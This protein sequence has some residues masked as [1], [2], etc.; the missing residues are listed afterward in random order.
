MVVLRGWHRRLA[1]NRR[2]ACEQ[3]AHVKPNARTAS[4]PSN[5][6]RSI[7]RASAVVVILPPPA[8]RWSIHLALYPARAARRHRAGRIRRSTQ[9]EPAPGTYRRNRSASV[10]ESRRTE[11]DILEVAF[12]IEP[13]REQAHHMHAR[14]AAVGRKFVHQGA[15]T[16]LVWNMFGQFGNDM[17]QTMRLSLA[18][19]VVGDA[20]RILNV[21]LPVQHLP[22]RAGLRSGGIPH[23][24]RED[25]RIA[26]RV[27]VEY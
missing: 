11:I 3:G 8:S 12:M 14:R 23:V 27:V 26:P 25:Q 1:G 13:R 18:G 24:D 22:D 21:L 19:D 17:A 6:S 9:R 2:I 15:F 7:G 5:R 4:V 16:N 10:D 20:T